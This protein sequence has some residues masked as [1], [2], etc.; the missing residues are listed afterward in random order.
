MSGSA[1]GAVPAAP[2]AY[3]AWRVMPVSASPWRRDGNGLGSRPG[4]PRRLEWSAATAA[5]EATDLS[6]R[7]VTIIETG[8][9]APQLRERHGT[10][11]R[12]FERMMRQAG[13]E[14]DFRT[15]CVS[16]GE[17]LPDPARLDAVLITGSP[18]GVY[19]DLPWIA[20]LEAFIRDGYAAST[21]MAGI[22]FGH[23]VMAQALGGVV[24][25]SERGWGLGRHV[26]EVTPG[27]GVIGGDRIAIACAHQ[28]QVIEAPPAARTIL[29]S[30]FSPHAGLLY[31]NGAMI[32][33][34]PHP[35]FDLDY[36]LACC[37]IIEAR[38]PAAVIAAAR[39]SLRHPMDSQSLGRAI[40]RFLLPDEG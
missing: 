3:A 21:P 26:Y 9:V 7:T 5:E 30:E 18:A 39:D 1:R 27:N 19:D 31:D 35:E 28:D 37:G 8:L 24:R 23:Q 14:A 15:V 22:C 29:A 13:V 16:E 2:R 12:M 36:A 25:Q 11:P 6:M 10:Y 38:A 20:P 33:V 4:V 17:A 34:Q 40:A 32:S